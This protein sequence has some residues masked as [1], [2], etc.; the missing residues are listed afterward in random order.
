MCYYWERL[1]GGVIAS[2]EEALACDTPAVSNT[3]VDFMNKDEIP[4]VGL[5]PK[6]SEDMAKKIQSILE[7]RHEFTCRKTAE[8]YYAWEKIINLTVR[9]YKGDS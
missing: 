3:L 4:R 7:G 2:V 9:D 8:K 5:I 1:Y 6:S